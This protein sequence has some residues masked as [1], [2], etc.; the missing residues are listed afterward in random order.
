MA[1]FKINRNSQNFVAVLVSLTISKINS[2]FDNTAEIIEHL[3]E[4]TILII[5]FA[6]P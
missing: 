3:P 5:E 2:L 4:A 6:N 1:Y